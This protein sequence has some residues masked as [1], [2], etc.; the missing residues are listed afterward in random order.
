MAITIQLLGL[1]NAARI[2]NDA[3][4]DETVEKNVNDGAATLYAV[5]VDNSANAAITY[6]KLYNVASPTVGT[7]VPDVILQ[8]PV[9][10]SRTYFFKQG[11][12]FSTALSFAAVTAGGTAG[13]T[14]PT[15][16]VI[17]DFLLG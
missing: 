13:T 15:S 12:V 10:V 1:T 17:V 16:A 6:V 3:D 8:V 9:S 11:L 7:T 5:V 2:I 14:G 4:I